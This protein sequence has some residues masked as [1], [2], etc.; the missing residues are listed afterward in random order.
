VATLLVEHPGRFRAN[1]LLHA[2]CL[3][4]IGTGNVIW[5]NYETRFYY[6]PIQ[7]RAGFD[8]PD[9]FELEQIALQDD[10]RDADVRAGRWER[11]LE[12]HQAAID[13]LVVAGSDP[14]LDA[15]NAR[16]FRPVAE[17]GPLRILRHR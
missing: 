5:D 7:F 14:R 3:L 11:L 16:W 10:P 8:R 17:Q 4:G 9:P 13:V 1:P 15:I 12:Q 2:D 6:F